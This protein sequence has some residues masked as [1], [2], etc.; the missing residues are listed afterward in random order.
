MIQTEYPRVLIEWPGPDKSGMGV[1]YRLI[2]TAKD[3][4]YL[5][6]SARVDAMN[7]AIWIAIHGRGYTA[8][9]SHE[10]VELPVGAILS[11][12]TSAKLQEHKLMIDDNG[13]TNGYFERTK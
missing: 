9:E 6:K 5:E 3:S 13:L 8:I 11:L 1:T 4:F 7:N 10:V 2:E 12:I